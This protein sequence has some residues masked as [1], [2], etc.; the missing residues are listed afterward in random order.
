MR[1]W[2]FI[3]WLGANCEALI[4]LVTSAIVG[5]LG[6]TGSVSAPVVNSAIL[7]TLAALALS[8][9]RSRWDAG[10]EPDARARLLSAQQS[11][12]Q[13]PGHLRRIGQIEEL[14]TDY[15]TTLDEE[16]AIRILRGRE[17][18]QALAEAR[19]EA[20]EWIFR[21]GTATFVR[22][23]VLPECVRR[24]R[25]ARRPLN[26]RLE[27]LDVRERELCRRY[28]DFFR[29]GVED[30]NEDEETWSGEGTQLECYATILAACWWKQNYPPLKIELALSPMMTL[31]R[32]D[33]TQNVLFITER[34]PRFPAM[35]IKE[36]RFFYD[37]WRNELDEQFEQS[38]RV[39]LANAPTLSDPPTKEEVRDLFAR[40]EL[41]LP[42]DF[43]D[44]HVDHLIE[45]AIN[46]RNPYR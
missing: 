32:W 39:P 24:A 20:K 38:H 14:I 23:V 15:R 41:P 9:L 18:D 45:Q 40:L 21:G 10:A 8:V 34:G 3:R 11:L 42:D 43:D 33:M 13:L 12:E 44:D 22:A 2:A 26:V 46:A 25:R 27:I 31:F 7:A 30:P 17:I 16:A 35:M 36:G 1:T 28:A 4:A 29:Y 37:Y 5:V 6:L 19:A